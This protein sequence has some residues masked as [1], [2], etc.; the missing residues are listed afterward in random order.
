MLRQDRHPTGIGLSFP[1]S[2]AA[3]IAGSNPGSLGTT[4]AWTG[5]LRQVGAVAG[6][7]AVAVI[8]GV[9]PGVHNLAAIDGGWLLVAGLSLASA[10]A[11]I[12]FVTSS[13]RQ[14]VAA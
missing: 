7:S 1:T 14:I 5:T 9:H 3:A 10:V 2:A 8:S 6:I 13:R 4:I 11:L 12:P